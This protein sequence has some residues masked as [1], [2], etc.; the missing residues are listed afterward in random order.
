M[1]L[2]SNRAGDDD[3]GGGVSAMNCLYG[4]IIM[5]TWLD[6]YYCHLFFFLFCLVV[7]PLCLYAI[8]GMVLLDLIKCAISYYKK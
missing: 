4:I 3:A 7:A 1:S 8:G 5:Y 6:T 2:H